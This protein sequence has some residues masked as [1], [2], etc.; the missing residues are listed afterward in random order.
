MIERQE[1]EPERPRIVDLIL[2]IV[3]L[4]PQRTAPLSKI[5]GDPLTYR[6]DIRTV[7]LE[8][9]AID[10]GSRF[11]RGVSLQRIGG[12][13]ELQIEASTPLATRVRIGC[14]LQDYAGLVDTELVA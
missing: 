2:G 8:D 6:D 14:V 3:S 13:A 9:V 7:S 5:N 10:L 1:I 11:I 4:D 12:L